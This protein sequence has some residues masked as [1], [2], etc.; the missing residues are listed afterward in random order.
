MISADLILIICL[1]I[2]LVG[3]LIR[4]WWRCLIGVVVLAAACLILYFGVFDYAAKWIEYDSLEFISQQF[5]FNLTFEVQEIGVSFRLTNL[6]D[7]FLLLQNFG[8]DPVYLNATS[9]GISKSMV[10]LIGFLALVILCLIV[11]SLLYWILLR[12][13]MPKRIRR[14]AISRILGAIIGMIEMGTICVVFFQFSGNLAVPLDN[15]VIPQLKDS[16]SELH[17]LLV[18]LDVSSSDISN[19]VNIASNLTSMLNPVGANSHLVSTFFN[20]LGNIGL[21]PFNIISVD[22]I[23]ENGAKVAIP[24]K[25]AFTDM[26]GNFIDVSVGKLNTLLGA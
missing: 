14:G 4:G 11:S 20:Y 6:Q 7:S 22:V 1:V 10:A 12:W 24:F 17:T 16:T 8:L 19:Y 15:I 23:D 18:N 25:D 26:L 13:I 21:S 5:G 9:E 3:G 2:G